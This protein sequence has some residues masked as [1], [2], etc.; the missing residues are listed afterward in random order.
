MA[1]THT[2]LTSLFDDIADSIRSKT[3]GTATIVADNFPTA[4]DGIVTVNEGTADATA[5]AEEILYGETAYVNGEKVTG[6]MPNKG[7]I[8]MTLSAGGSYTIS[9]GYHNG[10]GQIK[11]KSLAD[12]TVADATS[13][14]I[15]SGKTAYVNGSKVTGTI[16]TKTSSDF[17]A[18]GATVSVPAGYYASA[19]SKSVATAT[20]ATPTISVSAAGTI[21][22][23]ATQDAGYVS[24][25]TKSATHSL[26]TT[27][28][29]TIT[30]ST[31][32]QTVAAYGTYVTGDVVVSGSVNL[33]PEKIASG[34]NIFGVTGTYTNDA[35]AAAGEILSGKT[36]WVN[37]SKVTGTMTNQGAKTSSL[38]AG[39]SYTIPAGYHNGSGKVTANSLAS[40]TS[41]TATASDIASGKTAYVNGS[42]VTGTAVSQLGT[43]IGDVL[44][45]NTLTSV[46]SDWIKADG[47]ALVTK[48]NYPTLYNQLGLTSNTIARVKIHSDSACVGG[49]TAGTYGGGVAMFVGVY[50]SNATY[51]DRHFT[52]WLNTTSKI[53]KVRPYDAN[54]RANNGISDVVY[55]HGRFFV[56]FLRDSSN[57]GTT[58]GNALATFQIDSS[59]E[60]VSQDGISGSNRSMHGVAVTDSG[61]AMACGVKVD[62]ALTVAINNVANAF[63][64]GSNAYTVYNITSKMIGVTEKTHVAAIGSQFLI[65]TENA[66]EIYTVTPN[67]SAIPTFGST[68]SF[69]SFYSKFNGIKYV[70]GYAMIFGESSSGAKFHYATSASGSLFEVIVGTITTPTDVGYANG[71]YYMLGYSGTKK[72]FATC[73]TINGTWTVTEIGDISTD[74]I[75]NDTPV[76]LVADDN[77]EFYLGSNTSSGAMRIGE[78]SYAVKPDIDVPGKTNVFI[79]AAIGGVG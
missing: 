15:L 78:M 57:T 56:S 72:Y 17:T 27:K 66:R 16:P 48:A 63:T 30:P 46:N 4:I 43:G 68:R 31:E 23:S 34:V 35:N 44:A 2:T 79:R 52:A 11:A 14:D 39:G 53:F 71:K 3:G 7:A 33:V 50:D 47:T 70:N 58:Y 64:G 24:T 55:K 22:A 36:A 40:Q 25:G 54:D 18:S 42:K 5:A 41:A 51:G 20:Q 67:A 69:N 13:A 74:P 60:Y 73:A 32:R 38:N 29:G 62:G 37:G 65:I 28:G 19:A 9:K 49:V 10:S 1:N 45:S 61:Y 76:A 12:Q 6:T 8:T 59:N 75:A 21:T 77:G 26:P